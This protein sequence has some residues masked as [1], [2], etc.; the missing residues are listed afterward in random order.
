MVRHVMLLKFTDKGIASVKESPSRAEAFRAA[1]AKAGATVESQFWTLGEYDGVVVFTAPDD[2]AATAVVLEL[3]RH[4][5]V[6]TCM[7]RAF[8]A[9]EFKEIVG[10]LP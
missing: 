7:M 2:T 10:K 8:N 6:R 1:A 9:S 3:G 5:N 4:G